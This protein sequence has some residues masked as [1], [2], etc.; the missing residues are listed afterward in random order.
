MSFTVGGHEFQLEHQGEKDDLGYRI[1]LRN[2]MAAAPLTT[3][4]RGEDQL[5]AQPLPVSFVGNSEA[6]PS[7]AQRAA[8]EWLA[9]HLE[10]AATRV[11]AA[12]ENSWRECYYWEGN[13]M[14]DDEE[15][16][17]EDIRIPP[18][19][20]GDGINPPRDPALPALIVVDLQQ[21]WEIEHG[22]YVV[23]DPADAQFDRWT[24]WDGM[25]EIGL[26]CDDDA[27]T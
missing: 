9:S 1:Y 24:T 23:L 2:Q 14:E 27:F 7:P 17:I 12:C 20:T 4:G 13:E 3:W 15:Y 10:E 26:C 22:F 16:F 18:G 25:T 19:E 21:D 6:P 5:G 8:F 11:Q